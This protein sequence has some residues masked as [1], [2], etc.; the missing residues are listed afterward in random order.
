MGGLKTFVRFVLLDNN[1]TIN[2]TWDYQQQDRNNKKWYATKIHSK[3][4]VWLLSWADIEW[5]KKWNIES[6]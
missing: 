3:K 4:I 5:E 6:K 1:E 2:K